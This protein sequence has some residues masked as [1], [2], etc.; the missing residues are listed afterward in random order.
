MSFFVENNFKDFERCPPGSHLARC[1]RII[2]VGTQKSE[3]KGVVKNLRKIRFSWEIHGTNDEDM[4][5]LMEDGRPFSVMKEY[6]L[7]WASMSNLRIDLQSWRGK[8]FTDDEMEKFDLE[9]VLGAWCMLNIIESKGKNGNTYS[10]VDGV[11]PIP[12]MLK[13]KKPAAVNKNEIFNIADHDMEM[14]ETFSDNLKKKIEASPEW[15][16]Q[17]KASPK[18][19]PKSQPPQRMDEPDDDIPF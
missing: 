18:S 11:S 10:N 1:Y 12:S 9:T 19:T 2:D 7:S 5:I 6:T 17:A 15:T 16:P 3:F 8:A 14:F 13:N 4:P